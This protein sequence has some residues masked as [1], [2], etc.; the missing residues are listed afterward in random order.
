MGLSH[1]ANVKKMVVEAAAKVYIYDVMFFI[2][3]TQ[4]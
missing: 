2:M 3:E 4:L 1:P